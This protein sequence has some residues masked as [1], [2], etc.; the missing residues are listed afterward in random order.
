MNKAKFSIT[1][2]QEL[3]ALKIRGGSSANPLAQ[4]ECV[5]ASKGCGAGVDQL[6][7]LNAVTGCGMAPVITH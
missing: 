4:T 2:L 1:E 3:E 7:C 5:N 6:R